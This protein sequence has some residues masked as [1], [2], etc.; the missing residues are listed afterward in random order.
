LNMPVRTAFGLNIME[1][2]TPGPLYSGS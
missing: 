2:R 1:E